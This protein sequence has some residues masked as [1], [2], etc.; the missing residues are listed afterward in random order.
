MRE[1]FDRAFVKADVGVEPVDPRPLA[2]AL[3]VNPAFAIAC[4]PSARG[5]PLAGA[6]S[7]S[8]ATLLFSPRVAD[9]LL[10]AVHDL[11]AVRES[12]REPQD[13]MHE[14]AAAHHA[15]LAAVAE[16]HAVD[17]ALEFSGVRRRAAGAGAAATASCT[18]DDAI[19]RRRMRQRPVRHAAAAIP[20]PRR[21]A[22]ACRAALASRAA[23]S[24]SPTRS[25]TP[26]RSD[27][28]SAS[29]PYFRNSRPEPRCSP[30]PAN[31]CVSGT[32][33]PSD[34]Q[35]RR[36]ASVCFEYAIGRVPAVDVADFVTEHAGQLGFVSAETAGCRA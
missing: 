27:S 1:L 20:A 9:D 25:R 6:T 8:I 22:R 32:R 13:R 24:R 5:E 28:S 33:I 17:H 19:G 29:R 3:P 14:L 18:F 35:R 4:A 23:P 31:G 16:D 12:Q 11:P 34:G 2:V 10:G 36:R 30:A 15:L 21:A 7:S 26:S